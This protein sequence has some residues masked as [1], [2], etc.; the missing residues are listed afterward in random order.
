M[1]IPLVKSSASD[2]KEDRRPP[3][4]TAHE[5]ARS[6]EADVCLLSASSQPSCLRPDPIR[7]DPIRFQLA[8]RGQGE[9]DPRSNS[10]PCRSESDHHIL[11]APAAQARRLALGSFFSLGWPK[12]PHPLDERQYTSFDPRAGPRYPRKTA[13]AGTIPCSL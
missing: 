11:F 9:I 3:E 6:A 8:R 10:Y 5:R 2:R 13:P 4:Q 12:P 7:T 1:R